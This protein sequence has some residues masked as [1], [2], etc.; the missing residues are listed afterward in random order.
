MTSD[1]LSVF[2]VVAAVVGL[3]AAGVGPAVAV[4]GSATATL[5]VTVTD[6]LGNP[7]SDATVIAEWDGGSSTRTTA[8]NGKAFIDVPDGE[9]VE[10]TVEHPNYVRNNPV[11]VEEAGAQDVGIEV[12]QKA[13]ATAQV[14]DSD[15]SP[16]SNARVTLFKRGN[17]AARGQ[18]D[19]DGRFSTGTIEQG[20]Y[21]V[22]VRKS[23][24]Y[25][26]DTTV[27]IADEDT[28]SVRVSQGSVPVTFSVTDD[29]FSPARPVEDAQV[30]VGDIGT[31][32]TGAQGEQTVSVPVNSQ[33][34]VN[35]TK[36]GY[37]AAT[38]T[39]Q[40]GESSRDLSFT[41]S[42]ENAVNISVGNTQII[43]DQRVRVEVTDE[44]GEPVEGARVTVDGEAV[45][46]TGADGVYRAQLSQAGDHEIAASADGVSSESIV[47]E[48]I[49][50][51]D[52]ADTVTAT[53]RPDDDDTETPTIE[54]PVSNLPVPGFGPVA[55]LVALVAT[56]LVVA[57]RR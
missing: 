48:A 39:V 13:D 44:Y 38:R 8:G 27:E 9:R 12:F 41:I 11:V 6:D 5:T 17:V 30:E 36:D 14:V 29:H 47:V 40:V 57:R 23:G 35:V 7:L 31:L 26:N 18:T 45:G 32:N 43:V 52:D 50:P 15:G 49:Q 4:D 53:A 33:V 42:R 22:V 56:A 24:F 28:F 19:G 10:L 34:E 55:A 1:S 25:T 37:S 21:R 51:G 46:E 54:D 16:V 3:A 20:E 2:L